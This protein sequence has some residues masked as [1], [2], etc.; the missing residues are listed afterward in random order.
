MNKQEY[1][2]Q[3][4]DEGNYIIKQAQARG[5]YTVSISTGHRAVVLDKF[6]YEKWLTKTNDFLNKYNIT[7]C[8]V[9]ING[10]MT[11]SDIMISKL[12]KITALYESFLLDDDCLASLRLLPQNIKDLF[13]DEHYSQ[14]VFEAFKYVEV[15]V[16]EKS[17]FTTL[18]G[19]DLMRKA[20]ALEDK[21]KNQLSGPLNN[22]NLP[23]AEQQSQSDLFSGAIGFIKN[24][25]SHNII[26]VNKDKATEL[27][28]FANYLLRILEEI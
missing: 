5:Q 4:I 13:S 11:P 24:P 2:K 15:K 23:K 28:Y 19:T 21:N 16:K 10:Q 20:F 3:I 1:L 14:A 26:D 8:K 18:Y 7:N 12:A 27:L 9:Q 25:K 17:N 6:S 22:K